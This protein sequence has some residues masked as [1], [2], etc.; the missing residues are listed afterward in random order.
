MRL[1]QMLFVAFASTILLIGC[2]K[3]AQSTSTENQ[4]MIHMVSQVGNDSSDSKVDFSKS[5][6]HNLSNMMMQNVLSYTDQL[7]YFQNMRFSDL[8]EMTPIFSSL[9]SPIFFVP[10]SLTKTFFEPFYQKIKIMIN[11]ERTILN[12]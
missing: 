4:T 10:T 7:G 12:C 11:G 9:D 1:Q 5:L 2:S 6:F 3:P 8:V